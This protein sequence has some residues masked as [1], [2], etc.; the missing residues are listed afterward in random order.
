MPSSPSAPVKLLLVEGSDDKHVIQHLC[1]STNPNV[2]F[3]VR[4]NG[5]V[6][7]VIQS[8]RNEVR[9]PDRLSLGIVVDANS[10]L[11]ARWHDI[12]KE[13]R[14][15]K[16]YLPQQPVA[17]GTVVQTNGLPRVG[18]WLMPDN[19]N[20]GELE[21]FLSHLVP[22]R[23]VV[24]PLAQTY[25]DNAFAQLAANQRPKRAKAQIHAWL[26]ATNG[27]LPMGL[28]VKMGLFNSNAGQAPSFLAWLAQVFA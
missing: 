16:I 20:A 19:V 13:L 14:S 24:W 21:D 8:I 17:A 6:D 11:L 18:V 15:V 5:G 12:D 26:A 7:G 3:D 1:R 23:D 2:S 27:G 28:S 10:Q 9:V 25:V 22:P 4:A